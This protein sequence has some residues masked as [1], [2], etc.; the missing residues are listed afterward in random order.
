MISFLRSMFLRLTGPCGRRSL[1]LLFVAGLWAWWLQAPPRPRVEWEMPTARPSRFSLS[2]D[3]RTLIEVP[4]VA[5]PGEM[6]HGGP[7]VLRDVATG[8]ER[9]RLFGDDPKAEFSHVAPDGSWLIVRDS[10]NTLL[11]VDTTDGRQL[12]AF[13][14]EKQGEAPVGWWHVAVDPDDHGVLLKCPWINELRIWDA[15]TRS[16]RL[17]VTDA[18]RCAGLSPDGR[19][20]AVVKVHD[21]GTMLSALL[22]PYFSLAFN[23]LLTPRS[24]DVYYSLPET[25]VVIDTTTGREL[26]RH[27][28]SSADHTTFYAR[29]SPD[30]RR[31]VWKLRPSLPEALVQVW[32][33]MAGTPPVTIVSASSDFWVYA[34]FTSDGRVAVG[35]IEGISV[36]DL[37]PAPTRRPIVSF[38]TGPPG[39]SGPNFFADLPGRFL[40]C[41]VALD[42]L[43]LWQINSAERPIA[44]RLREAS[45]PPPSA[46]SADG[47]T[48]AVMTGPSQSEV[49]EWLHDHINFPRLVP[50]RFLVHLFDAQTGAERIV[51]SQTCDTNDY[52]LLGF[53][54]DGLTL[55]TGESRCAL[56]GVPTQPYAIVVRGWAVNRSGPPT[57]LFAVTAVAFL[58]VV[59]DWR[60][61]RKRAASIG[62]GE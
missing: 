55:W 48:F 58:F 40:L 8:Q 47:A 35:T 14:A 4:A 46:L 62:Q 52:Y 20:I 42:A 61:G 56:N 32:D 13:P 49:V 29:F 59:A 5:H 50:Q 36:W 22:F 45:D 30:G 17:V 24:V 38:P 26:A 2:P 27:T 9:L 53:S 19:L 60:R 6:R 31:L 3:G 44:F 12:A 34:D 51:F 11:I 15:H 37:E 57:W 1:L 10:R 28:L 18:S 39:T 41:G 54:P 23:A 43:Q 16:V 7:I 21:R 25:V 33:F